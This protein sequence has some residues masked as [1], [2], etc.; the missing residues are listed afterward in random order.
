M[1]SLWI[2]LKFYMYM[3]AFSKEWDLKKLPEQEAFE[4]FRQIINFWQID[5]ARDFVLG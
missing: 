1:K 5:N 4:A 3:G 2:L